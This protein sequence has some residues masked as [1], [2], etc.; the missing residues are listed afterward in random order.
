MRQFP[1]WNQ[2]WTVPG[3]LLR[4]S[5]ELIAYVIRPIGAFFV[6]GTII[7]AIVFWRRRMFAP[8]TLLA[9]PILLAA[10]ASCFKAY[11][12]G[13]VRVMVYA[14]PGPHERCE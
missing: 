14:A 1:D 5:A 13:G 8:W 9:T 12:Y 10:A 3:W 2:P 11:P 7:G 6:P 4:A